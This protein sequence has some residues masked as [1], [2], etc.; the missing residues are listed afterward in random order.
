MYACLSREVAFKSNK[1]ALD[2]IQNHH[3]TNS[4]STFVWQTAKQCA[5]LWREPVGRKIPAQ[6]QADSSV[7]V[8]RV[9]DL[10]RLSLIRFLR[11][12]MQWKKHYCA[13]RASE[14]FQD[15]NQE[16]EGLLRHPLCLVT[17]LSPY[18]VSH[19]LYLFLFYVYESFC[20]NYVVN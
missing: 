13:L 6:F 16:V 1:K 17:S 11:V 9:F 10:Q 14:G 5:A 8:S 12:K 20:C 7:S 3:S 19:E 4:A 2:Y 18:K 15:N